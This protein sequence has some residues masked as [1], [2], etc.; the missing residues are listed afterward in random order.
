MSLVNYGVSPTSMAACLCNLRK[1]S[2]P[3]LRRVPIS[4]QVH[5]DA[6]FWV[7]LKVVGQEGRTRVLSSWGVFGGLGFVPVAFLSGKEMNQS[8]SLEFF[9]PQYTLKIIIELTISPAAP[10]SIPESSLK[11][12]T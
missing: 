4:R 8:S 1:V 11:G 6:L 9:H 3:V 12:R 10:I 2:G 5:V 7:V